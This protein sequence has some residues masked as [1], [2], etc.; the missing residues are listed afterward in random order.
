MFMYYIQFEKKNANNKLQHML[1]SKTD[2]R[3][4][5]KLHDFLWLKPWLANNV[6]FNSRKEA[7]EFLTKNFE[8]IKKTIV[9]FAD[10]IKNESITLKDFTILKF[11]S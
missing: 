5:Q 1:F 8:E 4:N 7:K 9:F 2:V 3:V 11:S 10:K 6:F